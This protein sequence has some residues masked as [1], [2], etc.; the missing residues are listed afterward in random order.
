[1]RTAIG[2]NGCTMFFGSTA[3]T[4]AQVVAAPVV[5][6]CEWKG[7]NEIIYDFGK[8]LLAR[9]S[10]R[11][12]IYDGGYESGSKGIARKLARRIGEFTNSHTEDT[13]L[14][15]AWERCGENGGRFKY[16]TVGMNSLFC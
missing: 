7:L 9:A 13:W 11:V 8:L 15:A 12:M 2:Q 3:T 4:S 14:L 10:V 5:A 1:M 6:E 16:Y